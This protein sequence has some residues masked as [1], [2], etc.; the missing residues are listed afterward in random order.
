MRVIDMNEVVGDIV[1]V[2]DRH[3]IPAGYLREVFDKVE[4][5]VL[6]CTPIKNSPVGREMEGS[7]HGTR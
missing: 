3:H 6:Y 4:E 7:R 1:D 5:T 2:L